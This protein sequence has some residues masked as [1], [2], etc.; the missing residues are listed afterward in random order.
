MRDC[1]GAASWSYPDTEVPFSELPRTLY[2][3]ISA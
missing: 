2:V 3:A 1:L